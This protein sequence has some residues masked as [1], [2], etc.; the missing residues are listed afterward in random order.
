MGEI[1]Q[2]TDPSNNQQQNN[3][4]GR[5]L[6]VL[7]RR[8]LASGYSLLRVYYACVSIDD[9]DAFFAV[10]NMDFF[11]LLSTSRK[12]NERNETQN[13]LNKWEMLSSVRKISKRVTTRL[14]DVEADCALS[15]QITRTLKTGADDLNCVKKSLQCA[16]KK[17][18][19][20]AKTF[21]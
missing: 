16:I 2:L 7:T 17:Y 13:V 11:S 15:Q 19:N 4:K 12:F 9:F 20:D 18:T 6:W 1:K 8:S 3:N 5:R 21:Y 10:E 14:N